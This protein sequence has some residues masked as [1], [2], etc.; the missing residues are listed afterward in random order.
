MIEAKIDLMFGVI[1]NQYLANQAMQVYTSTEE[2]LRV[3]E[4]E[5]T[6]K[7]LKDISE[8]ALESYKFHSQSVNDA[9]AYYYDLF[10]EE[11]NANIVSLLKQRGI[12]DSNGNLSDS[13][14]VETPNVEIKG[15]H[16]SE[17]V[18]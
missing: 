8:K 11:A 5:E 4:D 12:Y 14:E 1:A 6:S 9:I 10:G 7:K 18:E 16:K 17:K 15:G 3:P 13:S 2:T